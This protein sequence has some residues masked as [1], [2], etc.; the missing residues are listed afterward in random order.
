MH[1][2]AQPP[3]RSDA[4]AIANQQ[5]SDP[6]LRIDGGSP[7]MAVEGSQMLAYVATAATLVL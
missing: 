1:I 7:C 2:L 4:E 6:D 5:P 3:L